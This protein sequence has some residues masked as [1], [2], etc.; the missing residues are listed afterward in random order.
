MLKTT[1]RK[2]FSPGLFFIFLG[3]AFHKCQERIIH[4]RIEHSP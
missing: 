2:N 4:K 3:E 1:I